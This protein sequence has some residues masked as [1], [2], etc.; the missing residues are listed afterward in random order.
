M[1][2]DTVFQQSSLV[3]G[4]VFGALEVL[5]SRSVTQEMYRADPVLPD[6]CTLHETEELDE[7]ASLH[8]KMAATR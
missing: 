5:A 3:S 6:W 1:Y 4:A 8:K 2:D 7:K